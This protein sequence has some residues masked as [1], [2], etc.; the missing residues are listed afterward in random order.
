MLRKMFKANP[1]SAGYMYAR[2]G[3]VVIHKGY[4]SI[5]E[6]MTDLDYERFT[7]NDVVIYHFRISTQA[8]RIEMSQPFPI[9]REIEELEA[10][11]IVAD[12]GIAHNGIISK[13]SNGDTELTDTAIYIRRY[14]AG[15]EITNEFVKNLAEDTEGNRIAILEG[16]GK[17]HLTGTW[18]YDNG[19]YYSNEYW[20]NSYRS[21]AYY[22]YVNE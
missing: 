8:N 9:T 21:S 11:D 22:R 15:R 2:N 17:F 1:H 14:V 13:T 18:T 16:D 6:L 5:E 7:E 20:K 19:L 12:M 10:L 4:K 3:N